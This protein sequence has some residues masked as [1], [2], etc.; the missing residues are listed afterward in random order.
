ML[1]KAHYFLAAFL[2]LLSFTPY[3]E[4][5]ELKLDPQHSYLLW[6]VDHLGFSTQS[7]KW[8][9]N[10]TLMLDKD[11]P[12]N[13]KVEVSVKLSE[14]VTGIPELNKHLLGPL[15]FDVAKFPK[16]TFVSNKVEV[17]SKTTAKVH[18]LLTLHG[19]SKPLSLDVTLNKVGKSPITDKDTV[20]FSATTV[21]K[22][23]DF[24]IKSLVPQVG[25]EVQIEINA[26][27]IKAN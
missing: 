3:A 13:S 16:A 6:R 22:R 21:I 19:E 25:D 24:G 26:E 8:Y 12:A 18:G 11:N 9:V 17:L 14:L 10:G 7:G 27:A 23:S 4:P 5:V 15:F 1:S 20:G 2:L